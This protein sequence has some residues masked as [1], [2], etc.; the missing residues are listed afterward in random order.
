MDINDKALE[1]IYTKFEKI[2]STLDRFYQAEVFI[3]NNAE[4]LY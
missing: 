3:K 1:S 2:L 4:K